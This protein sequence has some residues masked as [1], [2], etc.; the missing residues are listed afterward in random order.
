M[1]EPEYI[2]GQPATD[3]FDAAMRRIISK[4][5]LKEREKSWHENEQRK[6]KLRRGLFPSTR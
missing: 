6:A 2:E 3:K 5:E 1:K 4:D